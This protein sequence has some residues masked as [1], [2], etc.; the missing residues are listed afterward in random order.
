MSKNANYIYAPLVMSF[1]INFR[2][3]GGLR[4]KGGDKQ[5]RCPVEDT[6]NQIS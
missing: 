2:G 6:F 4:E 3:V 1:D 5:K